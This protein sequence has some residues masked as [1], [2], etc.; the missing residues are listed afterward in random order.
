MIDACIAVMQK[1]E[2]ELEELMT[3]IKGPDFPLGGT[4]MG[5]EGIKEAYRTG[6]GRI[7]L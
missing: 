5:E 3:F 4:I 7:Y 1:P 2:I 6:K